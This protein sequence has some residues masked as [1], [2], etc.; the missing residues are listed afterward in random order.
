MMQPIEL[1]EEYNA[2]GANLRI[3][4][5]YT[6][7]K[8]V[9]GQGGAVYVL[10]KT[11]GKTRHTWT[12]ARSVQLAPYQNFKVSST[13]EFNG[14]VSAEEAMRQLFDEVEANINRIREEL[15]KEGK[16]RQ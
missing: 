6:L 2:E 4:S 3:G 12:Y 11:N 15:E 14:D 10:G 7:L 1:I 8:I 13:Q 5:G 9:Q 16:I